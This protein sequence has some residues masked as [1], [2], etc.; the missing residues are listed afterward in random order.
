MT[1]R[2]LIFAAILS[3]LACSSRQLTI[4]GDRSD[5][6]PSGVDAS[7]AG[8]GDVTASDVGT[9]DAGNDAGTVR[10]PLCDGIEH[11]RVAVAYVGGGPG[12][13]GS[14]VLSENGY[15]LLAI[16]GACAYWIAGGWGEEPSGTELP[17]RTGKLSDADAR[18]LEDALQLGDI[19]APGGACA[20]AAAPD[21]PGR[22][23]LTKMTDVICERPLMSAAAS[24]AFNA[25]WTTFASVAPRL[26]KDG[27]PVE[28]PIHVSAVPGS[29][30]PASFTVYPWPLALPLGS[31]VLDSSDWSKRGVSRLVD[32]PDAAR[33]LRVLRDQYLRDR[34]AQ[35]GRFGDGLLVTDQSTTA[36]IY[37]R[38]AIPYE[39]ERG[40]LQF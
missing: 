24:M 25:T 36:V 18:V 13:R 19:D 22:L 2:S 29:A 38:D 8:P 20:S 11:L 26:W 5:A 15:A 30:G 32:D 6:G 35:P 9:G 34:S 39:D 27:A 23:I 3:I 12:A 31:F 1:S 17:V 4:D 28:G 33:Q 40:L 16:D 21:A 37:M 14:T 10:Q 7:D